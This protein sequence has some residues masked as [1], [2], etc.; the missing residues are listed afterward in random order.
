MTD[1]Q[2]LLADYVETGSETAFRE[3]VT[4]Y[5]G[6]VYSTALRLVEGD[7]HRADDVAQ[8]VFVDLARQA[9]ILSNDIRLG[10]WL[11]RHTCFVAAKTMR[12]ERRRQSRERQA[13]EM[14]ALQDDSADFSSVAPILDRRWLQSYSGKRRVCQSGCAKQRRVFHRSAGPNATGFP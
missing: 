2:Q 3:V 5:L 9:R 10:G 8:T 6:L 14:N 11:H 13:A 4:R 1:S 12:A 7:S